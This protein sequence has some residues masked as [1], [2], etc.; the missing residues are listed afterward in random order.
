MTSRMTSGAAQL[1]SSRPGRCNDDE[2][3]STLPGAAPSLPAL[4]APGRIGAK[5]AGTQ[6]ASSPASWHGWAPSA[7]G[8][9]ALGVPVS[10]AAATTPPC[11]AALSPHGSAA[12][13]SPP[14]S[15]P[16]GT[17]EFG[18]SV[19][20]DAAA[21][22]PLAALSTA[23][24]AEGGSVNFRLLCLGFVVSGGIFLAGGGGVAAAGGLRLGIARRGGAW[25]WLV[26]LAPCRHGAGETEANHD[27]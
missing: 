21:A 14:R 15:P 4:V 20:M 6:S 24:S 25:R 23:P 10:V 2:R 1:C 9:V 26:G 12:P 18:V 13:R 22:P 3:G 7:L 11:M 5:P 8:T 16:L 19:A 17:V 27:M